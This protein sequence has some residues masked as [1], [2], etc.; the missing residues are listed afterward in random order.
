MLILLH[1]YGGSVHHWQQVVEKLCQHYRVIV[2]NLGHLYFSTDKLSF[3][4][5]VQALAKFIEIHFPG[6]QVHLAGL[7]FGGALCW[8]LAAEYPHLVSKTALINPMVLDPIRHFLPRE[9]H[10]FFRLPLGKKIIFAI[11]ATPL[12]RN[13]LKKAGQIFRGE[14]HEGGHSVEHLSGRK[15]QF[16]AYMIHHFA[17]ILRQE[18]WISWNKK[19]LN[20]LQLCRLIYDRQDLLFNEEAYKKFA[21]HIGCKD[22]ISME[23]A[24][25]LAIQTHPELIAKYI[26]EFIEGAV[27]A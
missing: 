6:Q 20:H 18:D 14:R 21:L 27:A 12:G 2:P 26:V 1:G 3:S 23:G 10:F 15:L 16:V 19:L 4:K 5:Q 7:S 13:F 11:L 17:W 8:A 9:L 24:G 22:V 25:H